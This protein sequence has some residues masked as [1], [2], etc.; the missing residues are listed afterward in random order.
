VIL[1]Q[2]K[3]QNAIIKVKI[4]FNFGKSKNTP[5]LDVHLA[6]LVPGR[7]G[8]GCAPLHE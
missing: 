7:K 8:H 4:K 1:D 5:N 6:G 2:N 3:M